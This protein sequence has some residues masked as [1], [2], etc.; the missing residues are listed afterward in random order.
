MWSLDPTSIPAHCGGG[1]RASPAS[2]LHRGVENSSGTRAAWEG[3]KAESSSSPGIV[4]GA[5]CSSGPG[6]GGVHCKLL[7]RGWGRGS[8]LSLLLPW[9][10]RITFCCQWWSQ[11]WRSCPLVSLAV[12][13]P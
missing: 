1:L 3:A 4:T 5:E 7:P 6:A 13:N 2:G 9:S 8:S 10:Q 12:T 11:G